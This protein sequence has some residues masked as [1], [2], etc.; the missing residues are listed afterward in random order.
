MPALKGPIHR[1]LWRT[2][3]RRCSCGLPAP[4]VGRRVPA[5]VPPPLN[6]ADVPAEP[7]DLHT[8]DHIAWGAGSRDAAART[9]PAVGQGL[10]V[11]AAGHV[12]ARH[13]RGATIVLPATQQASSNGCIPSPQTPPGPM[14][15]PAA[16]SASRQSDSVPTSRRARQPTHGPAAT[17]WPERMEGPS[18]DAEIN[19]LAPRPAA[20]GRSGEATTAIV[21]RPPTGG[22]PGKPATGLRPLPSAT[23]GL[24]HT[25]MSTATMQMAAASVTTR[26]THARNPGSDIG[27]AGAL[28]P[29]QHHRT[30]GGVRGGRGAE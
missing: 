11:S 30:H 3:W 28:T 18:G 25:A 19:A 8:V 2:F 7:P 15:S 24:T 22:L 26:S 13:W 5:P 9:A 21:P 17:G 23:G 29:A 20:P 1:R 6:R 12:S 27:R 10:R 4:C 14:P 16:T